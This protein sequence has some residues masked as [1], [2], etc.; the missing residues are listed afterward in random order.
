MDLE[1]ANQ[2]ALSELTAGERLA[3][4]WLGE[5]HSTMWAHHEIQSVDGRIRAAKWF[6]KEVEALGSFIDD[7]DYEAVQRFRDTWDAR[8]K[9]DNKGFS[10]DRWDVT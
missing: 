3:Y 9:A 2:Q 5:K 4:D 10:T 8:T 7:R 6:A 1:A